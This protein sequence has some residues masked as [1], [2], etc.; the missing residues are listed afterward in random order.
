MAR[1]LTD[2]PHPT[3]SAMPAA[4]A[5]SPASAASRRAQCS[6]ACSRRSRSGAAPRRRRR[7]PP[8]R[9]R[10]GRAPASARGPRSRWPRAGDGLRTRR[11]RPGGGRG[12]VRRGG[13]PRPLAGAAVPVDPDALG[14]EARAS[15]P[16]IEQAVLEARPAHGPGAARLPRAAPARRPRRRLRRLAVVPH[17]RLQGALRRRP[18]RRLLS[19][20]RRSRARGA[21][22]RLPPALLDEHR[23]VA[24]SAPSRSGSS[25]TT[26]RSTRS[27]ATSTGCAPAPAR[28]AATIART[29]PL[30]DETSS[31]SGML[32]N[33]LELLVR[34]G[35]DVA[36]AL[37]MLVP[38]AWQ[39]DPELPDDVRSFHRFHARAGR[40]VGRPRRDRLHATAAWSAPRSTATGCGRCASV[41]A[42]DLVVLRLRGG[43]LRPA[44]RAACSAGRLGP[45][46]LLVVDPDRGLL[47]RP[48]AQARARRARAV[49][50]LARAP[51][52]ARGSVG[53]PVAA[54]GGGA[55]RAARAVRLHARGAVGRSS[56]PIGRSAGTSRPR[57]WATTPRCRCS[58][59]AGGRC[60][61]LL[62]PAL[63]A[64]DEP[65]DRPHPRALRHVARHAARRRAR[66]CSSRRP[67]PR[68]ASSSRASSSTLRA[69]RARARPARRDVRSGRG[70]RRG[71][72]PARRRGR[73]GRARRSTGCCC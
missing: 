53:E 6:T 12:G 51:G 66:R 49:R 54:A 56:A 13:H 27:A 22:R 29:G 47:H 31:D 23:A 19:R 17:G 21:V 4:S 69:R 41:V 72:R 20:P 35:R 36:H 61:E 7:R 50:P 5:S 33:A 28:S 65:G 10:C 26:A 11:R 63:R 44:R 73:G 25:A 71:V 18:A 8:H 30:L 59:A 55:R 1:S 60:Y 43:A 67:R 48:R 2:T 3:S 46:E 52:G 15:A 40:A 64:G 38:P 37:A 39:D 24:G 58:A 62:P 34:G 14:R 57:R 16:R 9:G 42:G 45:G 70:P 32:D 68:R